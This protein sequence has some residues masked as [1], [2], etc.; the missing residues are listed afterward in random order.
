MNV[1]RVYG[2]CGGGGWCRWVAMAITKHAAFTEF[3]KTE[4]EEFLDEFEDQYGYSK[5]C[6]KMFNE[7]VWLRELKKDV[8]NFYKNII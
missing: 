3:T 5:Y 1:L 6:I 4:L 2:L 8:K 7:K